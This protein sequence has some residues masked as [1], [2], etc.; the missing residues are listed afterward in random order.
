MIN[1]YINHYLLFL[2]EKMR[3]KQCLTNITT[4][5]L[6]MSTGWVGYG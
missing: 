4:L 6:G 2:I 1:T 3:L 5:Q